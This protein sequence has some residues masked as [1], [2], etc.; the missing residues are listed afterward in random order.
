MSQGVVA[1]TRSDTRDLLLTDRATLARNLVAV[2]AAAVIGSRVTVYTQISVGYLLAFA[3]V[4]VWLPG[5]L[6]SRLARWL[7]GSAIAALLSG[8]ALSLW[9]A[10]DHEIS[11][12][13]SVVVAAE[14]FGV[15]ATAGCLYWVCRTI[16]IPATLICYG[17]GMLAFVNRATENFGDSPWRFGFALPV[18]IVLFGLASRTRRWWAEVACVLVLC[19][20]SLAAGARSTFAI[21]VLTAV[22]LWVWRSQQNR[23]TKR[24][25]LRTITLIAMFAVAVYN[26]TQAFNLEGLLGDAAQAR[27]EAQ[28][29]ASGNLLLGGRPELGA[30]AALMLRSPLGFGLGVLPNWHDVQTGRAGMLA[31]G[32]DPMNGYVDNYMFGGAF[33]VHSIMGGLW[34]TFGI[35][36]VLLAAVL[37]VTAVRGI[38]SGSSPLG[39]DAAVL[40][41]GLQMLWNCFFS[42]WYSSI[43]ATVILLPLVWYRLASARGEAPVHG[44]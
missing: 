33:R 30:T 26:L 9:S 22:M 31:I 35:A 28:L 2:I 3:L 8:I 14:L 12:Q 42:P 18:T 21:L 11:L 6:R 13:Q 41:L 24:S 40:F 44:T 5:V 4:P 19:V 16:G 36:G 32:Y 10:Q 37:L 20:A 27:T 29:D 39:G 43:P 23:S 15:I 1:R 38:L 34:V 7:F 25:S 17:L